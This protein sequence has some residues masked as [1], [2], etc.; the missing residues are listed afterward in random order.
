VK[1]KEWAR[2]E[3]TFIEK[4]ERT[5]EIAISIKPDQWEERREGIRN[6]FGS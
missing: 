4:S 5:P 1:V 3:H 6:N 2:S